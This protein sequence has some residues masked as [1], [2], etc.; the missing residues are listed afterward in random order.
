MGKSD[1]VWHSEFDDL[2]DKDDASLTDEECE[3]IRW[4]IELVEDGYYDP[5]RIDQADVAEL[6][7]LNGIV[8]EEDAY[9]HNFTEE[10]EKRL[11]DRLENDWD[12]LDD[13]GKVI[14]HVINQTSSLPRW[15]RP[16]PPTQE[17]I[18]SFEGISS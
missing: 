9:M 5:F 1:E 2:M 13:Y 18:R 7:K 6:M 11:A 17:Y 14:Y 8:S 16:S 4:L 3:R 15:R 10:D 12:N